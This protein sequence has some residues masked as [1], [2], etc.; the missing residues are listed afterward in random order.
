[1]SSSD[2]PPRYHSPGET[3]GPARD[4]QYQLDLCCQLT[5]I[6][7]QSGRDGDGELLARVMSALDSEQGLFTYLTDGG[8]PVH[9][10]HSNA[11]DQQP[12]LVPGATGEQQPAW[13]RAWQRAQATGRTQR[14]NE[15]FPPTAGLPAVH[16]LVAVPLLRHDEPIGC[17]IVANKPGAYDD[18]DVALLEG[19]AGLLAPALL[20]RVQRDRLERD[21]QDAQRALRSARAELEQRTHEHPPSSSPTAERSFRS[22]A[23]YRSLFDSATDM[24]ALH[25]LETGAFID[26]NKSCVRATGYTRREYLEGGVPAFSPEDPKYSPAEAQKRMQAAA[27]GEPQLFEWGFIHKNGS[28]HPTEVHLQRVFAGERACLLAIV[29]DISAR[30][31][32]ERERTRSERLEQ[33]KQRL[34]GLGVLAGGVAHDFNNILQAILGN[35]EL[36]QAMLDDD[37]PA[38][39]NLPTVEEAA[40]RAAELTKQMLA[41]SGQ[42]RFVLEPLE[43]ST[44]IGGMV[45]LL[46]SAVSKKASVV[47][48]LAERLTTIEAD[49][50]QLRQIV[51]NLMLNA[52]DAL[53]EGSGTITLSTG[54]VNIPDDYVSESR[55]EWALLPGRY[56]FLQVEDTGSGIDPE[57]IDKVFEPF[58]STRFSGRGMGLSA[59]LGIVRGHRGSIELQ[60]KPGVGTRVRILLPASSAPA[61]PLQ[62]EPIEV[63]GWRG[64]GLILVVDDEEMVRE[65]ARAI[66]EDLGFQVVTAADGQEG[67]E[68]FA[69]HAPQLRAVLLDMIMP[70]KDGHEVFCEIAEIRPEVP[71]ILSSGYSAQRVTDSFG[72]GDLAG[73]IQKPYRPA[74][75]TTLL[76]SV[77]DG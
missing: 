2:V 28:F 58:F 4:L 10:A 27:G 56:V 70:L 3:R 42:G 36:A 35:A 21:Q 74:D 48:D 75:L 25:D 51:M 69:E 16:C 14:R 53:G 17:L 61:V 67:V 57:T 26:V 45:Q 60:S 37:S 30:R 62:P 11:A 50:A 19:I 77:L 23:S 54:S 31:D 33:Q 41:Y 13:T 44:H 7:A 68:R 15:P 9:T 22:E 12:A 40:L 8:A 55:L 66:L 5:G 47:Y 65:L 46:E 39:S 49:A 24:I 52:S 20:L 38:H 76:R 72:P 43:L 71:V 64:H 29:R 18:Q 34:E 6:L 1:M 63:T 32:R 73:F 59:V